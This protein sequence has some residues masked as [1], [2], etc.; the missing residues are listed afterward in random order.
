MC[1][2]LIVSVLLS[3]TSSIVF[4]QA[5][6]PAA[7]PAPAPVPATAHVGLNDNDFLAICGDSITEQK[8]YSLYMETYLLACK[9]KA[10]LRAMQFGW[11]G[12]V[13]P[14]FLGRMSNVL[15][16]PVTAATTCYGMN[17]GGYAPLTPERAQKYRDGMNGIVDTFKKSGV[18]FIVVGSPG[19]VDSKFYRANPNPDEDKIYNKTLAE[20]RDIAK[21]IATAHG[22]GFADVHSVM[23]DV[24]A[25]AKAKYGEDYP[26]GGTDG[27]HPLPNGH[28]VMAYAFLKALG[29]DGNLGT[30]TV[31]LSGNKGEATDGHKVLS[32]NA[33]AVEVESTRYPFC[34]SGDPK[35]PAATAGVIE[36]F[37]FNQDLNRL[38]LIVNNPGA[39][40]L[41]VTW[42][43]AS[44]DYTAAE[45][46]K[47]V[48]LAA[49]FAT[50]P[51]SEPFTKVMETSRA[52]QNFE[53][54]LVKDLLH[55]WP[56]YLKLVPEQ[57]ESLDKVAQG[58]IDK[59][60]ALNDAAAASVVP[61]KHV[62]KIE[63]VP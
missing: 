2:P 40:K 26:V 44:K 36:F 33:G 3:L 12:E 50:N 24:M 19:V 25:K 17:D 42:G 9:P 63:K 11:G 20:L 4:A 18:R 29:C 35:D 39:E 22:A 23:L 21:E 48:N 34:V 31:D 61:V 5:P 52:Q 47:G 55:R 59:A 60:R 45:L 41:K 14:G 43:A 38:I 53:T 62:I 32:A 16:F 6:A 13:A 1:R 7:A 15:R 51:F 30:I 56:E 27:V 10:N 54:P 58:A 28:L 49:D 57:K 37:P 46:A 8:L